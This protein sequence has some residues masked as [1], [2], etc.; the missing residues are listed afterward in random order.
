MR[1]RNAL[2]EGTNSTRPVSNAVCATNHSI[3]QTALSTKRNCT[4]RIVMPVNTDQK[5]TDLAAVL[6]AYPWTLVLISRMNNQSTTSRTKITIKTKKKKRTSPPSQSPPPP[7]PP[8]PPPSHHNH[9]VTSQKIYIQSVLKK[10]IFF[11]RNGDGR[12]ARSYQPK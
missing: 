7:P 6:V 12:W 4:A 1:P 11:Y 5:D 10:I 3:P 8:Q 2:P 9:R